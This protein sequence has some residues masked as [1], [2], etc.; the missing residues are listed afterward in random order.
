MKNVIIKSVVTVFYVLLANCLFNANSLA[1]QPSTERQDW[2]QHF[3]R[4]DAKG[5]IVIVDRRNNHTKNLAFNPTRAR[6]RVSPASTF[7][8]AHS[9]MAL[10]ARLVKDQF[11]VFKWDGVKRGYPPQN[12]DQTLRSAMRHSAVWVYDIFAKELGE[13]RAKNYLK[14]I[15][16]GNADPSTSGGSYWIDGK[17]AISAQEQVTFL[18]KLYRNQLP[19]SAGHQL[20]VNDVLVVEADKKWILR[21][22]SGWDGRQ[23]W[24]IGWV[25]WQ[26]GPV[27][28]ALNID[29]P[30]RFKDL[31]KREAL[32]RVILQSI[33]AL[34]VSK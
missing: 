2:Q 34:P 30:N 19:F 31:Y 32:T 16:Y 5:T 9:L 6:Q 10:D 25:E 33:Q 22:K 15:N 17:L 12:Q 29:T 20:L 18:E 13:Q 21:A 3:D 8:I 11:E 7:K 4:F 26:A 23:G 24:W 27:F 28:F 14:K 1:Q